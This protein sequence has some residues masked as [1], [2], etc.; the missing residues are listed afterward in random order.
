MELLATP[1]TI[2]D[3]L[4]E[5]HTWFERGEGT[6][7]HPHW[8]IYSEYQREPSEFPGIS[9]HRLMTCEKNNS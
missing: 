4:E 8:F 9:Y 5:L 3:P 2:I 7:Q 1:S 6:L